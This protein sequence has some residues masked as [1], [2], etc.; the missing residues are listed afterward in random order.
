[1][2]NSDR[3][4]L[5]VGAG[6][7]GL[8]A[9]IELG[10][11]GFKP[12]LID[13]EGGP[14]PLEES[15]ALAVNLRSLELLGPSGLDQRILAEAHQVR[16]MRMFAGDR[17]L[18][19][20]DTMGV[21]G[22]YRGLHVLPLG[23]TER[24]QLQRLAELEL[25]PEWRTGL[26]ALSGPNGRPAATLVRP[27]GSRE[28]ASFDIVI[29]AD[30]AHSA[31]RKAVGLPFAGTALEETFYIADYRY[32][33]DIDTSFGEAHFYDPGVIARLPV[34]QRTLRYVST[35]AD[36]AGR[37]KHPAAIESVP[38]ETTF[39]VSFRHVERM[40]QGSVF[41]AGDA[42]HIHSPV[43]G[44]GMNLGFEDACW[45][46]WLIAE[47]RESEYSALRLP[48]VKLVVDETLSNTRMILMKN[49][50]TIALRNLALPIVT[51]LP[52][53]RRNMVTSVVGLDTPPPPWLN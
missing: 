46:A 18:A 6:P 4:I 37:I 44:R 32:A 22:K 9:A 13:S 45:L 50:L 10:R 35:L 51:R 25:A 42:A 17:P 2:A 38:W 15:R 33:E 21:G 12:R 24:I 11:R 3:S 47:G 49:P 52:W 41:L 30:G 19:T 39:R 31:V 1:M 14:T 7:V 40:S 48:A 5:I 36:F 23:R 53:I 26:E 8:M 29:G 43:G 20:I 28:E 34:D 16:Q 27:D